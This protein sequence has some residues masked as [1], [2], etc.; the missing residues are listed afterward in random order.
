MQKNFFHLFFLFAVSFNTYAQTPASGDIQAHINTII[1]NMPA[2]GGEDFTIPTSTEITDWKVM[3]GHILNAQYALAATEASA[4]GYE[5]F[6]Y[7]DTGNMQLYYLLEEQQPQSR[8]WGTFIIHSNPCR[9]GLVLQAPHARYDFNTAKEAMY[10]FYQLD[11]LAFMMNG[12]HRC[13]VSAYSTCTGTTKVCSSSSE[14]Y[15]KSDM[16][17]NESSMFHATTD[18]LL[19]QVNNSM[20]V[21]LH[22][23]A[24]KP[25]DPYVIMSNGTDMTPAVDPIPTFRDELIAVDNVLTFKIPHIDIGWTRLAGFQNTQGRMING[26]VS[27]CSNGATAVSGRFI[28]MEQEK[29]RL[30]ND[31]TGWA[32]VS[33]ALGNTFPCD[34]LPVEVLDFVATVTK[35]QRVQLQWSVGA[36]KDLSAYVLEKSAS[37]DDFVE[38][39]RIR[40]SL[41]ASHYQYFDNNPFA[42]SNFYRL[43]MLDR[44]G[45]ISYSSTIRLLYPAKEV[46]VNVF[47]NPFKNVLYVEVDNWQGRYVQ[48]FDALGR[49]VTARIFLRES[50]TTVDVSGIRQDG[51]Y[52]LLVSSLSNVYSIHHIHR[53]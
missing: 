41:S 48:L 32:K 43:K 45:G 5:L 36:E 52:W 50:V 49:P 20:F 19:N 15:R 3:I 35:E 23:F 22:G 16:A 9:T 12:T 34:A 13:N 47:P 8:Y 27:P 18:A 24:K 44:S 10:V 38:I 29:M 46:R 7:T 42:G 11:A 51:A 1:A 4:L 40:P 37:G 6:A 2:A 17:H 31:A 25:S 21:Q 53:L 26:Q 14:A 33:T 39:A 30:R 28:H